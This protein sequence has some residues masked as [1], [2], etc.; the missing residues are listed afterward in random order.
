MCG[1]VG[2]VSLSGKPIDPNAPKR[3]CDTIAHRGPDDAGYVF[4]NHGRTPSGQGSSWVRFCDAEF[5]HINEHLPVFGGEYSRTEL[6][7]R[8]FTLALGHRRLSILDLTPAGHQ[9]MCSS[10]RLLWIVHNGEIYNFL[11]LRRDLEAKGYKFRTRT[12]TEVIL[13]LWEEHGSACLEMLDGMFSFAIYDRR[14]NTLTLARDR[15]GVKPVYYAI[16]DGQLAFASEAKALFASRLFRPEID[17][18]S[19]VEYMSFQNTFTRETIWKGVKILGPGE[20]LRVSPASGQEPV[21]ERYRT[22]SVALGESEYGQDQASALVAERFGEAVRRQL[23]SDV[24][25]GSYLSGGMDSGSIVAVAGKVIDRLHTFTGGFDLTN[26]NGIEQG[27]DERQMAEQLSH[28]LQTEHYDVVLHAGDM[29][30]A[31]ESLT[32]H[33][34]DPRVGMCHQNWYVAKLASRFVKVCLAGTGGDELFAGYPW[35]Y[36]PAMRFDS[37]EGFDDAVFESWHR[38]LPRPELAGLFSGDMQEHLGVPRQRFDEVMAGAPKWFDGA[39]AAENLTHRALYFE[40][41]TFL[42]GLLVTDDHISMAHSLETR[43]PFLDNNLADLAWR[44]PP[45]AKIPLAKLREAGADAYMDSADGKLVLRKAMEQYLPKNFVYN[46]KQGFSPPDEN[47]YRG[48]SMD[49]IKSILFDRQTTD[50]PWFD[51]K[52]LK[53]R[54]DEHFEGKRNHRLLIWSLLS[55]EWIQRHFADGAMVIPEAR[56]RSQ[57][58]GVR[59]MAGGGDAACTE[60]MV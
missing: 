52:F 28:L 45:S 31:M 50:R 23:V 49:Y 57:R 18:A 32:W 43:V 22:Q 41:A 6:G 8:D 27:F 7:E 2:I 9:P 55:I 12:D 19:L 42:H 17:S 53:A 24:P 34:D 38:L 51:Q 30:A 29:P 15:F 48:P 56:L 16:A 39:D 47:W 25:V 10:D 46:S 36:R 44:L 59:V 5:R 20:T 60:P 35:R 4:F 58:P 33:M 1:I 11:E 26:V 54:L 3:M 40:A 13:A 14:D 37:V 21:V